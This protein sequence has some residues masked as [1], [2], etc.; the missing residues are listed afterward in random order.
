MKL[1]NKKTE[2][3]VEITMPITNGDGWN[4]KAN[5]LA[6]LCEE[7]EDYE[8]PKG[9]WYI[10][11]L[12]DVCWSTYVGEEANIRKL[13]GNYFK[14]KEEAEKAVEKLKAWKRLKDNGFK[15]VDCS[16]EED[17][18]KDVIG[19]WKLTISAEIDELDHDDLDLLFSGGEE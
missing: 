18:W 11:R 17:C 3:I 8:E 2:E 7:W 15:F 19:N 12:G 10:N 9:Y 14:T 5:S 13:I 16:C 1:R 6:E 4:I